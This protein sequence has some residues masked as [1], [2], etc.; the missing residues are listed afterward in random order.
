LKNYI[1]VN[2]K[3]YKKHRALKIQEHN[4]R[5][6]AI[7]YLLPKTEYKNI[8]DTNLVDEFNKYYKQQ[9][10]IQAKRK[11]YTKKNGNAIVEMVVALSEEMALQYLNQVNGEELL[12]K[13]FKQFQQDIEDR[14]GFKG[15]QVSLHT[16]EGY[17]DVN[18]NIK[19]NIHAHLTFLNF[20]FQTEKTVLANLKRNDWS[21]MQDIAEDSFKKIGLDFIRGEKK[22]IAS[23]DHLERNEYILK[24]Q[25][26]QLKEQEKQLNQIIDTIASKEAKLSS[27]KTSVASLKTKR[28]EVESLDI[29]IAQKKSIYADITKEQ[30]DIRE[31]QKILR[32]EI[33]QLKIQKKEYSTN[34]LN[35][36]KQIKK[37]TD[38]IIEY[39]SISSLIGTKVDPNR[40]APA[41]TKTL[42]KYTNYQFIA[43]V[44]NENIQLKEQIT[45]KDTE[46][47]NRDNHIETI[48]QEKTSLLEKIKTFA[49]EKKQISDVVDTIK[50]KLSEYTN[51]IKEQA[52]KLD[53]YE[54]VFKKYG[55]DI[56]KELSIFKNKK[57]KDFSP[58][59]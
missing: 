5:I 12:F 52:K 56:E 24:K 28:E 57:S 25:N 37:D 48:N 51:K 46:I 26:I 31:Q 17:V 58:D 50:Q 9:Q 53:L 30:K 44:E 36:N 34:L 42:Q 23:K 39:A 45:Q 10:Q 6:S 27:L 49:G 20:D 32:E 55:I 59:F 40:L 2:A 38:K 3:Y 11:S 35:I 41:I 8:T 7:D 21:A 54:K 15:L 16:D 29:D 47:S 19:Y 22:E 18:E 1:S 33:K 13:G 4:N 43:K 14:Y